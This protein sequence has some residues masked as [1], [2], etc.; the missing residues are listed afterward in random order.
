MTPDFD[1]LRCTEPYIRRFTI[2][3]TLEMLYIELQDLQNYIQDAQQDI[4]DI[5][6]LIDRIEN[7]SSQIN[8]KPL[9]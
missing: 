5:Q 9:C 8:G 7:N 4:H 3:N 1:S 2:D 6:V